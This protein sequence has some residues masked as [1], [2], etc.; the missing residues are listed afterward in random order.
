MDSPDSYRISVPGSTQVPD[1]R[2]IVFVYRTI[3][4]FGR[5]SHTFP[6]T[7]YFVTP[8]CQALQ[9][10]FSKL[11][12]F[13]LFPF[14]SPLLRELFLF[15]WVLRCFSSPGALHQPIDSAGDV[16]GSQPRVSPFGNPRINVCSRLPEAYRSDPRPSSALSAKASTVSP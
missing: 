7:I 3:T 15:L 14:R 1:G 12:R 11:K 13:G 5:L 6:L 9:P 4:F 8:I 16:V 10:R 2:Q